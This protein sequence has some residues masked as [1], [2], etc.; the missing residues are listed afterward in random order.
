MNKKRL[1][2]TDLLL[3]TIGIGTWPMAGAG[4]TGWGPQDDKDSITSIRRGLETR[5]QL[6]RHISQLWS[7]AF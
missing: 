2:N 7:R 1:G 4:K 6:D 5:N 3:T